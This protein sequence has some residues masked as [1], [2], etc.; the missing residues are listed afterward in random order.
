MATVQ[1]VICD[2]CDDE[3]RNAKRVQIII[4]AD[5]V[6]LDLCAP[7]T[8][9]ITIARA[10]ELGHLPTLERGQRR[11]FEVVSP[12]RIPFSND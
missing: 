11:K 3:E 5:A 4:D 10:Y 12:D 1:R 6:E 9:E 7:H 2:L 8:E